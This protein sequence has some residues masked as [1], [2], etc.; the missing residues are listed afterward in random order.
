MRIAL[1]VE[2]DGTAFAG[3]QRQPERRTVQGCVETALARVAD[4]P[5]KVSCAGRTDAGVHARGQVI[6]F[7]TRAARPDRAWLL[8]GNSH[9]PGDVAFGTARQV[10][11]DFHARFSAIRRSYRYLIVNRRTR[12]AVERGVSWW[13]HRPLDVARMAEAAS[14]LLGEHDFSSFRAAE[15]Q[16]RHAVRTLYRLDVARDGDRVAL[17]VEANAFLHHMVRN[18]TG[19]LVAVG[20][21]AR[22]PGWLGEVLAARDR[23]VAAVTA[24]PQGLCFTSVA[25]PPRYGLQAWVGRLSAGERL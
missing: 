2:Y 8:G 17:A 6:H 20:S 12:P 19:A 21:G 14:L 22:E 7:D 23:T 16:A 4:H 24:P 5:V 15:C 18:I 9:L 3:W 11:D 25:Y 1:Q 13:V 10:A